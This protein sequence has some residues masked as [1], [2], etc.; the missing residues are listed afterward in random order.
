M[1]KLKELG[2]ERY[3]LL[4]TRKRDGTWV[5]TPVNLVIDNGRGFFKSYDASGKAKRLRNFPEVR[6]TPCNYRGR[7]KGEA[8]AGRATLLG[9]ES[10]EARR[11]EAL[12]ARKHPLLQ[13]RLVP[14]F[15]KRKG[16]TTLFYELTLEQS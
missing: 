12:L 4:E 10:A 11:A 14:A 1:S 2:K 6:V 3:L 8:V 15:H 16:F 5:G 7:V 13:G 9:G